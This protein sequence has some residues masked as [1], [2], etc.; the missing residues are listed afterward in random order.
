MAEFMP[1]SP[2][3]GRDARR[4]NRSPSEFQ[5][6]V[7]MRKDGKEIGHTGWTVDI[8]Q[9]GARIKFKGSLVPGQ[10]VQI[11]PDDDSRSAYPCRVVWSTPAQ[12]ERLSEAGLEFKTP[13]IVSRSGGDGKIART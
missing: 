10:T 7:I 8:S 5:L 12:P 11:L 1:D 13:W 2:R 4:A 9:A 3:S 6:I